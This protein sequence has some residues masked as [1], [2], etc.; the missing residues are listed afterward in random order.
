MI[1]IE[2]L[3]KIFGD[4]QSAVCALED[5]SLTVN[6]GDIFGVG[7]SDVGSIVGSAGISVAGAE[8]MSVFSFS[9]GCGGGVSTTTGSVKSSL[10]ALISAVSSPTRGLFSV[11][12]VLSLWGSA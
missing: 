8:G 6:A 9:A 2:H 5:V 3:T 10:W 11:G 4:G 1:Q 7:G 12:G